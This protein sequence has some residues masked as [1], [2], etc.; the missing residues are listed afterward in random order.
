M[1]GK[2]ATM[3]RA[4]GL[5]ATLA[6]AAGAGATLPTR[7]QRPARGLIVESPN[8]KT[9]G[10]KPLSAANAAKRQFPKELLLHWAF[11]VIDEETGEALEYRQLKKHPRLGPIW[12]TSYSN[13][14]GRLCQ[15]VG[16]GDKGPKKQR[17][18]GTDTFRVIK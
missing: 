2:A 7:R 6:I 3:K 16:R 17:V 11:P 15:G 14:M 8:E 9:P 5:M 1:A 18:E 4:F 10:P 12:N 13:E